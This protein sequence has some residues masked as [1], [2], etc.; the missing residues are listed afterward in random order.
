[1]STATTTAIRRTNLSTGLVI[2]LI[3]SFLAILVPASPAEAADANAE[4]QFVAL[5]NN[6][7]AA[8]G[9]AKLTVASDL[10]SVA[11]SHSATMAQKNDL[12]HNPNLGSDVANWQKVGEN[13]GRG[14]SVSSIHEAFM[15][16]AGHRANI[17]DSDWTEVGVGV[18]VVDGRVWVTEVFRQPLSSATSEPEPAPEPETKTQAKEEPKPAPAPKKTTDATASAPSASA[19]PEQSGQGSTEGSGDPAPLPALEDRTMTVLSRIEAE[20]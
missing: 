6:E 20:G 16:S 8:R 14:P 2:T 10:V 9:L 18:V 4:A 1:M 5:L 3:V 19:S 15:N 11:R 7:R 12:Y 17:L 13:V